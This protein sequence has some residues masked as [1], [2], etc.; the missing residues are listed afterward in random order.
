VPGKHAGVASR[1]AKHLG[2]TTVCVLHWCDGVSAPTEE[3]AIEIAEILEWDRE[4]TLVRLQTELIG[5]ALAVQRKRNTK[6]FQ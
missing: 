5:R 2:V 1:I 6:T 4:E 3:Q